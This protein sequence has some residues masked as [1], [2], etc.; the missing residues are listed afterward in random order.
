MRASNIPLDCMVGD[1]ESVCLESGCTRTA[2]SLA[3][4][5]EG[6]GLWLDGFR[7]PFRVVRTRAG[8]WQKSGGA[9]SWFMVDAD[10]AEIVASCSPAREVLATPPSRLAV[11]RAAV[12]YDAGTPELVIR[13]STP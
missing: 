8:Y 6:L 5:C 10:G 13:R 9:W 1:V 2:S 12:S 3:Q 4:L 7:L 11:E